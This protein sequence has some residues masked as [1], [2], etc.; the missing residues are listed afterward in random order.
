MS[1]LSDPKN[2]PVGA[3]KPTPSPGRMRW[4]IDTTSGRRFAVSKRVL[5]SGQIITTDEEGDEWTG[6]WETPFLHEPYAPMD[7]GG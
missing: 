4:P 3:H 2:F 5:A 6:S 7:E 1:P